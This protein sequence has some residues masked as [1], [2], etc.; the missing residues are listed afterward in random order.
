MKL[1]LVSSYIIIVLS[2]VLLLLRMVPLLA[3][4]AFLLISRSLSVYSTVAQD[5]GFVYLLMI[6][7]C[8]F[9]MFSFVFGFF[10]V[11]FLRFYFPGLV[12][13]RHCRPPP[14]FRGR[15]GTIPG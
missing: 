6:D 8:C 15:K 13:C 4:I 10:L 9:I 3:S 5:T 7:F 2:M 14:R 1:L 12:R 11:F